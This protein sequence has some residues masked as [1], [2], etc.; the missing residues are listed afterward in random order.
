M[1]VWIRV[2]TSGS[3]M[4]S[5]AFSARRRRERLSASAPAAIARG[6][7]AA[8]SGAAARAVV[9]VA[10][11]EAVVVGRL[12]RRELRLQPRRVDAPPAAAVGAGRAAGRRARP[13]RRVHVVSP[14]DA[15]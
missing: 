11:R 12:L 14:V 9:G 7:A 1:Y 4:A 13:A 6:G 3:M 10:A 2:S 15:R 5:P 8:A